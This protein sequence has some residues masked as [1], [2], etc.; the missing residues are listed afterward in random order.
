VGLGIYQGIFFLGGG[1]GPAVVGS[2]LAARRAAGT[3]ALN[4]LYGLNAEAFSDAFLIIAAALALAF[5]ASLKVQENGKQP[6][7]KA[8]RPEAV[9]AAETESRTGGEDGQPAS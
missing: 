1:T 3:D 2:F 5:A 7:A 4:P 8:G 6:P 9:P